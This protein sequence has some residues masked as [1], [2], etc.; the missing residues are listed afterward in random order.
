MVT[1]LKDSCPHCSN[2]MELFNGDL[3]SEKLT[4]YCICCGWGMVVE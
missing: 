4:Y 2:D 1:Y 3:E